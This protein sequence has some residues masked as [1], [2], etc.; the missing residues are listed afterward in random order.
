M[1]EEG[2][3]SRAVGHSTRRTESERLHLVPQG[4]HLPRP[5]LDAGGQPLGLWF[6]PGLENKRIWYLA[7]SRLRDSHVMK[8]VKVGFSTSK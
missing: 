5:V 3:P 2:V 7:Q 1:M 6:S 4:P 8:S